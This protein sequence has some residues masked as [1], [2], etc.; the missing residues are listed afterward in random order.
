MIRLRSAV[1]LGLL[2]GRPYEL[3]VPFEEGE[4]PIVE[5]LRP[6]LDELESAGF[7]TSVELR[8]WALASAGEDP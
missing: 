5:E 4:H 1:P 3:A 7:R 6:V 2:L 8:E